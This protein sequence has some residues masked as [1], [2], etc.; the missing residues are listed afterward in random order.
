MNAIDAPAAPT[1]EFLQSLKNPWDYLM[2]RYARDPMRFVREVLGAV[3][4][5]WQAD[6]L[7]Q[8][9][10]GQRR[11]SVRSGHAVGK[12]TLL[13]WVVIW[14][15][16]TRFPVKVVLTAP[17]APQLYDALWSELISWINKLP[18]AWRALLDHTSDRVVLRSAPADAFITARTARAESPE[19]MQGIHARHVMMVADEASGVPDPVFDASRSAMATAGAIQILAGNPNYAFG[20]FYQTHTDPRLQGRWWTRRVPCSESR[21]SDPEFAREILELRGESSNEYRIRVLGEFPLQDGDRWIPLNLVEEAMGRLAEPDE[22]A[23]EIWGLDCARQGADQSVLI[24]RRGYVVP[25]PPRRLS[26]MDVM[27]V[28]GMVV[29]EWT[30]TPEDARPAAVAVDTIGIG[31]PAADRLREQGLPVVDVDVTAVSTHRGVYRLR[32]QIWWDL[33]DWLRSGRVSLP[34]DESLKQALCAPTYGYRS[35]GKF[36]IASKDAMRSVLKRSPDDADAL[37]L[38]LAPAVVASAGAAGGMGWSR[39]L[40]RNL[41]GIV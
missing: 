6:V 19:V 31:G 9:R 18:P 28:V 21:F 39:P 25:D 15:F 8:L 20:F 38:T 4:E 13:A 16:V 26:S 29:A 11:I 36:T 17:S 2:R 10:R 7:E 22:A 24:K 5:P 41:R 40:R 3:P 23:P 33:L 27:A 32:D 30:M 34:L 35:D 1:A 37:G 14:F 12:T